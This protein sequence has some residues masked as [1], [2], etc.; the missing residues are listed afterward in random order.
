MREFQGFMKNLNLGFRQLIER[1][2]SNFESL[3]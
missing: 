2:I 3:N 1:E